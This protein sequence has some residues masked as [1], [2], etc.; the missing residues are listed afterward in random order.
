LG[1]GR[2]CKL[3]GARDVGGLTCGVDKRRG[4]GLRT[5]WKKVFKRKG[6]CSK[7]REREGGGKKT[8]AKA[9]SRRVQKTLG[10]DP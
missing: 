7:K 9:E 4:G 2:T 10:C 1:G 6:I 8:S 5:D 3:E